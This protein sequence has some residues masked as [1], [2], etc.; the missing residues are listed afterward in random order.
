MGREDGLGPDV[1]EQEATG[2]V[3]VLGKPRCEAFLPTTR[4]E[5]SH[6]SIRVKGKESA[7]GSLV[8]VIVSL[9]TCEVSLEMV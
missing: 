6:Q 9:R 5:V 2:A 4:L 7:T 8:A 1:V 3:R